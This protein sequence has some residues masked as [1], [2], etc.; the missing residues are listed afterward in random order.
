MAQLSADRRCTHNMRMH[1]VCG[2]NVWLLGQVQNFTYTHATFKVCDIY[3]L[4]I[5]HHDDGEAAWP[6]WCWD[7]PLPAIPRHF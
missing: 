6:V 7:S 5:H 1:V 2:V 4:G 3:V